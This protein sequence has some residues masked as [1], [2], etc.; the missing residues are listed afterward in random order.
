MLTDAERALVLD[1]WNDTATAVPSSTLID[2]FE[3]RALENP[4]AVAVWTEAGQ[5]T[6]AELD[7]R[8]TVWRS[9]CSRTA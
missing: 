5:A 9:C 1:T 3:Q 8:Q 2:E 7:S 4:T 6:Y